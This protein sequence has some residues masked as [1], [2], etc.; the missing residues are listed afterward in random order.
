MNAANGIH[1]RDWSI[2]A[3]I[4]V[5]GIVM[6]LGLYV[7]LR[8]LEHQEMANEF[9]DAAQTHQ[10]LFQNSIEGYLDGLDGLSRF[11]ASTATFNRSRFRNFI[12]S[13]IDA[14]P[15]IQALE[16]IPRVSQDARTRYESTARGDGFADFVI[17]ERS[18]EGTLVAATLRAEYYPVYY[19]EPIE[20]NEVALGF[21]LASNETRLTALEKARDTGRIVATARIKLV[22][23]ASQQ[24]GFLVFK[25]VYKQGTEPST[26]DARRLN[27]EGF[28]LGV[29]RIGDILETSL[30]PIRS[31]FTNFDITVRDISA[32]TEKQLL[33]FLKAEKATPSPPVSSTTSQL[34][35]SQAQFEHTVSFKV[36]DRQWSVTLATDELRMT[37]NQQLA[38]WAILLIGLMFTTLVTFYYLSSRYNIIKTQKLVQKRTN[39]LSRSEGLIRSVLETVG[40]GVITINER[41]TVQ[42]INRAAEIIFGYKADEV[43]GNNIVMLMP[44][45]YA[46]EHDGYLRRYQDTAEKRI[47]GIGRE[48]EGLRKDGAHFP[49]DLVVS[50]VVFEG[51]SIYTGLVRDITEKKESDKKLHDY[52]QQLE[53]T[54]IEISDALKKAEEAT[55]AKSA[56][57]AS[58]SHELRTP[59][60]SIIGFSSVLRK[61]KAQNLNEKDLKYLERLTVNATDLL[62]LINDILDISKIEAGELALD[63]A[64]TDLGELIHETVDQ[65]KGHGKAGETQIVVELPENVEPLRT[66]RTRLKQVLVNLIGNALKFTNKGTVTVAVEVNPADR[67]VAKISV[68]DTG[69]GIPADR[70]QMIFEAFQ[71]ADNSISRKYGGTGL[72]L[73]ISMRICQAMD[74]GLLVESEEGVGSTFTLAFHTDGE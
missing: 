63:E 26:I 54:N 22:Q 28:M 48:V 49:L 15:E 72:G 24:F 64:E 50:E 27:I 5:L 59:L 68:K 10:L 19:I 74:C 7:T 9:V 3:L 30:A 35:D 38:G 25:P 1:L 73:A 55:L 23:E 13:Y 32:P 14:N 21:D 33:H 43:I 39:E 60:N 34:K 56:F 65:M 41:G 66:D 69:I 62:N 40:D 37:F 71:Q 20:G 8:N 11:Y 61:N 18:P 36:A 6:T 46:A 29:F 47:I 44:D 2:A 31:R 17:S 12:I 67:S 16:W 45:P 53:W 4:F 51:K 52:A 42:S 58:M 70:L 57:L